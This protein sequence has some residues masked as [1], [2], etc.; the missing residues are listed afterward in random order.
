VRIGPYTNRNE[1]EKFLLWLR[2][3]DDLGDSYITQITRMKTV[4]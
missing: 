4:N 1:A 3:V 2:D